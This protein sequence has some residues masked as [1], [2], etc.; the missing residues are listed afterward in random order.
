MDFLLPCENSITAG[1]FALVVVCF[2]YLTQRYYR[3]KVKLAPEA[4]GAWPFLGHLPLFG[5]SHPPHIKFGDM[6]DK[7]GP[8]FSVRLGV[9][10]TL[11]VSSSEVAKE[12]FTALDLRASSRPKMAAVQII[13]YNNAMFGFTSSGPYW[14]EIRRIATLDLLS[15]RRLQILGHIRVFEVQTF[16]NELYKTWSTANMIKKTEGSCDGDR[17]VLVELKQMLGDLT[18]NVILRMI[19]GKRYCITTDENQKEEARRVQD[20]FREFSYFIGLLAVGDALPYLQWLDLGGHEKGM[21]KTAKKIDAIIGGWLEEHK[22]RKSLKAY[23]GDAKGDDDQ[24]FMDAMISALEGVDFGGYD[25]DTVNKA[26]CLMLIAG[27]SDTTLV[28]LTWA[29][30]LLL[31]NVH[32]LNKAQEELDTVIGRENVVTES[33]L[34]KLVYIQAI[35][36]ETLRLYPAAPLSAPHEFNEDCTLAGY[37]VPKGTR[38]IT[39]LWKIQTDP[40]IWSDPLEFK[41]ERFLTTHKTTDVRGQHFELIPFGS[42]RR[43]CPG[44]SFG[45]QTVQFTLA[46][47]LH[48]F[49]IWTPSNGPVDM[50]ESSGLTNIK[51][52]PLEV[53]IKPRLSSQLYA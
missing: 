15:N 37:H 45:L 21:K 43:V 50:S 31:N 44:L 35:V 4:K 33:D 18:L 6:A 48:A 32:V 39:N 42:G 53:L 13:G 1:L 10:R 28:T 3:P 29:I 27:G 14:R 17:V 5:G 23:G 16:L 20:A 25:A 34:S 46:S 8:L 26:T 38:L 11:V 47:F 40:R 9:H 19:A 22:R 30:S 41:P 36:K 24:D 12:C 51:A 52:T 49:K 2:Y 7:Y